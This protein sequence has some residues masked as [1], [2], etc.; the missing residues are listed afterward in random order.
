M[1]FSLNAKHM[2]GRVKHF[3]FQPV[4]RHTLMLN[5]VIGGEVPANTV[6]CMKGKRISKEMIFG[7]LN[8]Y[9]S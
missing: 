4:L 6:D 1:T 7:N 8:N 2:R 3:F 9:G 5:L